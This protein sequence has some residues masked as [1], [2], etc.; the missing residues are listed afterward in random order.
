MDQDMDCGC[1][2]FC[3]KPDCQTWGIGWL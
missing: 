1:N 3:P 2:C